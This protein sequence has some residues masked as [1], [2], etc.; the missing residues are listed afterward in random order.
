MVT[1]IAL[2]AE[3]Q[4]I[5]IGYR[6][7]NITTL[8]YVYIH[9]R[10]WSE[11]LLDIVW[12]CIYSSSVLITHRFIAFSLQVQGVVESRQ[13][14]LAVALDKLFPLNDY[15]ICS[16]CGEKLEDTSIVLDCLHRFCGRCTKCINKLCGDKCPAC[17][18]PMS[19]NHQAFRR[20]EQY[21]SLVSL[22]AQ[23]HCIGVCAYQFEMW[24]HC[25]SDLYI[26]LL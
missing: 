18:V 14:K 8:W 9:V 19:T 6:E 5:V 22:V 10:V 24:N 26:H 20:D 15:T 11:A 16:S 7:I 12:Y 1:S 4:S 17:K 3:V 21:D 2:V 25:G 13:E 23:S